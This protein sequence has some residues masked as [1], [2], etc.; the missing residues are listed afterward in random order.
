MRVRRQ[1][2][3]GRVEHFGHVPDRHPRHAGGA[4]RAGQFAAHR[5]QQ[6]RAALARAGDSILLADVGHQVAD[7]ERDGQ[8][9]QET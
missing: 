6:G 7:R 5:V 9:D 4:P 8:H 3:S 1:D 2:D